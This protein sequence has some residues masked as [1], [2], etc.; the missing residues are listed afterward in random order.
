MAGDSGM[1]RDPEG[2]REA[3]M[4]QRVEAGAGLH[5]PGTQGL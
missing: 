5:V 3:G 1:S 2:Y 4:D